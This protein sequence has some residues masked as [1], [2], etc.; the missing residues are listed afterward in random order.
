MKWLLKRIH[1]REG[2]AA[3]V[4][5]LAFVVLFA[6]A[7]IA[8]LSRTITDRQ[9]ALSSFHQ[10]NVD[11]LAKGAMDNIIGDLRQE[12]IFG[13]ASPAPTVSANGST[14]TLYVPTTCSNCRP[15]PYPGWNPCPNSTPTKLPIQPVSYPT[16]V[17]GTT[18]A[19]PNLIRR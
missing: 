18:P 14:F 12:I 10:S 16:P 1:A 13:S 3:L 11:Q 15:S 7:T 6:G 2:G 4:I 8:Y 5:V 9:V 17:A 19:I